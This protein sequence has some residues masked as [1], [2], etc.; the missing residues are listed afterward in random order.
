M[1]TTQ[2][3]LVS[4]YGEKDK[5][6][7]EA[8]ACWQELVTQAVGPA[9]TP[10]DIRQI[11]GT[12]IGLERHRVPLYN[13]NFAKYREREVEMD[14][15]GFLAYL[16]GCGQIPFKVQIGGF[17]NRDY[18]FTSRNATPY[19]RSFSVQGDK[20]VAVG[21]P[22]DEARTYPATLDVIRR[23]AQR[24]GI[25]HGYHRTPTDIDNDLFF[26]IGLIDP[27]ATTQEA[28]K[29]L[30]A[31][32]RELLSIQPLVIEIG[33]ADICIAAYKDDRLPVPS[34]R[35]WSLADP[36]VTGSFVEG[37]LK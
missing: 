12:I 4:L 16:Q 28:V 35:R 29:A 3:T 36:K 26:R 5:R 37:L 13:A 20:V 31:Q 24:F 2:V 21:W 7:A 22:L 9:F 15:A 18:S 8:I 6:F 27:T 17:E 25:L 23:E 33:L 10:Y 30:E 32:A 34:T 11:H 19:A 1:P 14:L